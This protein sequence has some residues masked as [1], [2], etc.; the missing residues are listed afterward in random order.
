MSV[1]SEFYEFD[2][3]QRL[4]DPKASHGAKEHARDVLE[5]YKKQGDL[6]DPDFVPED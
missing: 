4:S 1:L 3:H 5:D 6:N 2:S